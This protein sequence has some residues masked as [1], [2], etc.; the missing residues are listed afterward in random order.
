MEPIEID[1]IDEPT[2][3]CKEFDE[4]RFHKLCAM[5]KRF[6]QVRSVTVREVIT[7]DLRRFQ[8]LEGRNIIKAVKLTSCPLVWAQNVGVVDDTVAMELSLILNELEFQTDFVDIAEILQ[9]IVADHHVKYA[10][11]LSMFDER[12]VVKFINIK[13][14]DW[15]LFHRAK[16]EGHLSL[17]E[18]TLKKSDEEG[19]L[20]E[21]LG[22]SND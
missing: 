3:K 12:D 15:E 14:F 6:G 13:K 20:Q 1:L 7:G 22:T 21:N 11:N 9:K 16:R 10:T 2:W 5:V 19:I 8:V 4:K 18:E 17:F